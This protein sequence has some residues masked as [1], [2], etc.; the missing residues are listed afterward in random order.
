MHNIEVLR[1]ETNYSTLRIQEDPGNDTYWCFMHAQQCFNDPGYRPCFNQPLMKEMLSYLRGSAAQINLRSTA[2]GRSISH[3]VVASDAHVFNLGG[4]LSLFARLIRE[5]DREGLLAYA[6][7]C[8]DGVHILHNNLH[9]TAH[10]IALVEG[11][12]LG[13]GFELALSCQ[14]II[15]ESGVSMGFPEVLF[16]LFP[17][18]GAYSFLRK[19]LSARLAEEMMLSGRIYSSD[20]LHSMGVIDVLVSK[21]GGVRAVEEQVH[22]NQRT[23]IARLAVDRIRQI[24]DPV[25][26]QELMRIAEVWVDSALQVGEKSLRTMERL[27]HAQLRRPSDPATAPSVTGSA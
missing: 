2:A 22:R 15:A 9:P 24:A 12:A 1:R 16:G 7:D 6:R 13:G 25:T 20:E 3:I 10:T 14:T 27:V 19:R 11:D 21:G 4:D 8:I 18:M 26:L 5:G 17:G 23:A